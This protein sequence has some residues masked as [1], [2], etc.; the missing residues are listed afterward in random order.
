M[1]LFKHFY[2]IILF[3]VIPSLFSFLKK[4]TIEMGGRRSRPSSDTEC[5]AE[6]L[7]ELG[8]AMENQPA[9]ALM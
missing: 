2:K 1:V 9:E 4:N 8:P 5:R 3:K 7:E 6:D